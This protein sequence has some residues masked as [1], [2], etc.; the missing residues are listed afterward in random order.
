MRTYLQKSTENVNQ[1]KRPAQLAAEQQ[2]VIKDD[3]SQ[4]AQLEALQS[5]MSNSPQQQALQTKQ[6]ISSRAPS[7]QIEISSQTPAP[8]DKGIVQGYW[9][10]A[11]KPQKVENTWCISNIVIKDRPPNPDTSGMT[12]HGGKSFHHESAWNFIERQVLQ[13]EG[14]SID[15]TLKYLMTYGLTGS[16]WPVMAPPSDNE[17]LTKLAAINEYFHVFL[18]AKA[19]EASGWLGPTGTHASQGGKISSA[20][21]SLKSQGF[22]NET[23]DK[24]LSVSFE[25]EPGLSEKGVSEAAESHADMFYAAFQ[26]FLEENYNVSIEDHEEIL[27]AIRN[28]TTKYWVEPTD[29]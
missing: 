5:L 26:L 10:V 8:E 27:E 19:A 28:W 17:Q 1:S 9:D 16:Q 3:R 13:F 14:K 22:T 11:C 29:F 6:N 23:I 25:P 2:A 20:L 12:L 7:T 15:W 24:A 21:K 4:T 18:S